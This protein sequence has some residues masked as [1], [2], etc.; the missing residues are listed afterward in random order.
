MHFGITEHISPFSMISN[1]RQLCITFES[2]GI[3]YIFSMS[4][5]WKQDL[6]QELSLDWNSPPYCLYQQCD[7]IVHLFKSNVC[8]CLLISLLEICACH[9]MCLEV[10]EQP[11][12]MSSVC[13][14]CT[15]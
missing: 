9:H 2:L 14:P 10:R 6:M 5:C 3:N 1:E 13:F 8:M 7:G 12:A 4:A 11:V 15:F